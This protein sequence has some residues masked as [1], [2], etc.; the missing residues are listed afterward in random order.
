M[1]QSRWGFGE[2]LWNHGGNN[3]TSRVSSSSSSSLPWWLQLLNIEIYIVKVQINSPN[4]RNKENKETKHLLVG[5]WTN[6][7]EKYARQNGNLPQIG[8]KINKKM[9]PPPRKH[10]VTPHHPLSWLALRNKKKHA[11]NTWQSDRAECWCRQTLTTQTHRQF[12]VTNQVDTNGTKPNKI[13]VRC[14]SKR[15]PPNLDEV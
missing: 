13:W 9:K 4:L 8:V 3:W 5:G 11:R 1:I 6:P 2:H 15:K 12:F 10:L 14:Q 7:F